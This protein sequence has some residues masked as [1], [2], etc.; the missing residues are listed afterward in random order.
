MAKQLTLD[1]RFYALTES[2]DLGKATCQEAGLELSALEE[3]RFEGGEFK[4]RP[5]ASV[6]GRP[7]FLFLLNGLRDAGASQRIAIIPYLAY[8][9]KDRRTQLRDPVNTRYVAQLLE[10]SG[11][12][13][14]IALDI[15]NPAALDNA[16]RIPVDHLTALPTTRR[17][18]GLRRNHGCPGNQQ[19]GDSP[20]SRPRRRA[21]AHHLAACGVTGAGRAAHAVW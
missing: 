20:E 5:L 10:A 9:R 2:L 14:V 3:R 18:A 21:K 13:R 1:P 12:D 4:L 17:S 15:H 6:R 11:A 7:A 8:A 19:R 16:F